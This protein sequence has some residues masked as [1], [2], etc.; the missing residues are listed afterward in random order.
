MLRIVET[1]PVDG[2][3]SPTALRVAR[4]VRRL[5]HSHG[6]STVTEL[7]LLSGRRADVV[8]LGPDGSFAIIEIKSSIA[9]FRADSKWPDYLQHCDRFYFAIPA[10]V[11]AEIIPKSAGL[12]VADAYGAM[13]LRESDASKMSAATRKAILLRFARAAADRLHRLADPDLEPGI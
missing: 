3:Q 11:P 10:E 5:F 9:D 2:R 7:P 12:I 13:I 4:G 6:H 8:A 1:P